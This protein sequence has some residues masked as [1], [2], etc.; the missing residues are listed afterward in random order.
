MKQGGV[1]MTPFMRSSNSYNT[2]DGSEN[3][4]INRHK[5]KLPDVVQICE[6]EKCPVFAAGVDGLVGRYAICFHYDSMGDSRAF[7]ADI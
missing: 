1:R 5:V 2:H 7:I 3:Q 4:L 6:G